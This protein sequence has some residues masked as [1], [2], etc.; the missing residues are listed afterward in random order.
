MELVIR[1]AAGDYPLVTTPAGL[2][3]ITGDQ[4]S[5][6]AVRSDC[7]T[8]ITPTLPRPAGS[9]AHHRIPTAKALEQLGVPYEIVAAGS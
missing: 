6:R 3:K 1:T 2:K 9:G 5:E 7:E 4:R 8:G